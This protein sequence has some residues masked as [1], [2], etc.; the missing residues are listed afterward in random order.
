MKIERKKNKDTTTLIIEG[1]LTI[2]H[3][4][5]AKQEIFADYEKYAGKIALDLQQV[6]EIDTAGVQLLL[7]AKKFFSGLEKNLYITKLNESVDSMLKV[8]NLSHQ[9]TH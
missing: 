5:L 7:F 1:E 8:L 2:Y 9:F 6:T 3:V 4:S